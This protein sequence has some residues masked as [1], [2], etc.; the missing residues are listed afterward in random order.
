MVKGGLIGVHDINGK[1]FSNLSGT[2]LLS[3]SFTIFHHF[4]LDAYKK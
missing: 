4:L 1:G 3:Y 2:F